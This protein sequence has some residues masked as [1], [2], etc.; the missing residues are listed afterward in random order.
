M[1]IHINEKKLLK[2]SI[3]AYSLGK[4]LNKNIQNRIEI[5]ER[6]GEIKAF[7]NIGGNLVHEKLENYFTKIGTPTFNILNIKKLSTSIGLSKTNS[8][9]DFFYKKNLIPHIFIL[10]I[11]IYFLIIIKKQSKE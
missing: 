6:N 9:S 8:L 11:F 7:I 5:Y 3:I 4:D 2:N 1:I 10:L